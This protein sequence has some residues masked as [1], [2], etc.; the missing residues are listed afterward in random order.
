MTA[1]AAPSEAEMS[2]PPGID[3]AAVGA[4]L[5][6]NVAGVSGPFAYELIAGGHSNLTFKV[7]DGAGRD[8]VLRR[9]PLGHILPSAHDMGREFRIISGLAGSAV[10]VP[11]PLGLCEDPEVTGGNFY[12]MD[13]VD[14][15][16]LR[17]PADTARAFPEQA[18]RATL[19]GSLIDVLAD[20]HLLDPADV[21]LGELGRHEGYVERQLRRWQR[22]WEDSK[23]RELPAIDEV[24]DILSASVPAQQ[25]VSIVHGDYRLDNVVSGFDARVAAVLDWELCTLGDPLADLGGLLISWVEDGEDGSYHF[26]GTPTALPGFPGRAELIDRYAARSGLDLAN[27]E[28]YVGFAYWK[29]ACIGEGVYA[30]YRAGAMGEQRDVSLPQMAKKVELLSELALVSVR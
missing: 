20:L 16:I 24:H 6:A 15:W 26:G 11:T 4:W 8:F 22:Q 14:G 12:A 23:T 19:A 2:V 3:A 10:P 25:R 21:G 30:R 18:D 7:R 1:V 13:F 28:Y 5:E 9:Q 29:L 27:V 17:I